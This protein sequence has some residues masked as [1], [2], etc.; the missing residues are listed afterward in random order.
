[1]KAMLISFAVARLSHFPALFQFWMGKF[2]LLSTFA[3][4]KTAG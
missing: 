1:M 3:R 4:R 2:L